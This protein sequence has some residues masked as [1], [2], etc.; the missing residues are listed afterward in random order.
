MSQARYLIVNA[1]DLGFTEGINR[2][3]IEAHEAGI[4]TSASLM[5]NG[6]AFEHAVKLCQRYPSLDVGAHLTL[7]Q[8][9]SL[10]CPGARLPAS[11]PELLVALSKGQLDPRAEFRAQLRRLET[12]GIK[13]SH[14]DTHKHTHLHPR[15]LASLLEVAAEFGIRWVRQPFDWE[16]PGMPRWLASFLRVPLFFS[17]AWF[18]RKLQQYGCAT[19][20]HF[21]G[22]WLTGKLDAHKLKRAIENLRSGVTELMCHP[23]YCTAELLKAPTRLKQSREQEL[24]ALLDPSVRAVLAAAN[25]R[26]VNFSQLDQLWGQP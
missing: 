21:S 20:H 22:F 5:A 10:S 15:V 9:P 25:V 3:I 2:G 11:L 17:H 1:D 13:V 26:L 23:G 14:L 19:T 4:L 7:V 6:P 8:L 24:A 16:P 12:V 18:R